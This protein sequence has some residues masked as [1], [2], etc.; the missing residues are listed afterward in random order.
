LVAKGLDGGIRRDRAGEEGQ[1][2]RLERD[3][4]GEGQC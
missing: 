4:V 2:W 1:G 3:R